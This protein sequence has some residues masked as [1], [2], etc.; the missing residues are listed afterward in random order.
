MNTVTYTF[1]PE[2]EVFVLIT[3][4]LKNY[5]L[6]TFIVKTKIAT[7][8]LNIDSEEVQKN[9]NVQFPKGG[10]MRIIGEENIFADSASAI[11]ALESIINQQ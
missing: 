9:Y 10:S 4:N 1:Q 5:G 6:S 2:Q 8:V 11:S 7:V 3:E